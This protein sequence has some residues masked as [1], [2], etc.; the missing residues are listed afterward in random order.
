MGQGKDWCT[1]LQEQD[2]QH[3]RHHCR[4]AGFKPDMLSSFESLTVSAIQT[5]VSEDR[6]RKVYRLGEGELR[7][8]CSNPAVPCGLWSARLARCRSYWQAT[9]SMS[10]VGFH[11][12]TKPCNISHHPT[13]FTS[14]SSTNPSMHGVAGDDSWQSE[15]TPHKLSHTSLWAYLTQGLTFLGN[16]CGLAAIIREVGAGLSQV[17]PT[18]NH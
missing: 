12:I 4:F 5:Y 18:V 8:Q 11:F 10:H 9:S 1:M 6:A 15:L 14:V 3:C 13:A 2:R 7:C 16:L 17:S